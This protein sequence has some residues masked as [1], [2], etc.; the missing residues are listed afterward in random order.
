MTPAISTF[1][2]LGVVGVDAADVRMYLPLPVNLTFSWMAA[3][4]SACVLSRLNDNPR[5]KVVARDILQYFHV[6]VAEGI[7]LDLDDLA[8]AA[9]H[10]PLSDRLASGF[11]P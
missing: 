7:G 10:A 3:A 11:P 4:A 1:V 8:V 9:A 2:A 5:S 6:P